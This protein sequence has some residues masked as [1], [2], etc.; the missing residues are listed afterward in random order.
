M[1]IERKCNSFLF[2]AD[3]C[4]ASLGTQSVMKPESSSQLSVQCSTI[5]WFAHQQQE[6]F[7]ASV[8]HCLPLLQT[9]PSC[10]VCV[11]LYHRKRFPDKVATKAWVQTEQYE[12]HSG[13]TVLRSYIR[14]DRT[15]SITKNKNCLE[16]IGFY[17]KESLSC[18]KSLIDALI[19]EKY[20]KSSFYLVFF[21]TS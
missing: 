6:G 8:Q 19:S 17:L 7:L 10:L 9:L 16:Q 5:F 12:K 21:G 11:S 20:W 1:N 2:S 4:C 18:Y 15:L 14:F 13:L 3:V